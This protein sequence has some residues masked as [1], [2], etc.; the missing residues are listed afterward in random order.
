V[1]RT[2]ALPLVPWVA[3][4][5]CLAVVPAA[6]GAVPAPRAARFSHPSSI[7]AIGPW[8]VVADHATN[9]LTVLWA[10]DGAVAGRVDPA[11]LG[12][13]APTSVV[14]HL[15]GARREA[16]VAGSGGRVAVLALAARGRSLV[17][18]RLRMLDPTGC[19]RT[20][21][22]L[23]A[24][25]ARGHLVEAC[26]DGVLTEWAAASGALERVIPAA[27]THVTDAT[28]LAVLGADAVVVNAS[29]TGWGSAADG[30]TQLS[31]S[32]GARLRTVTDA[33]DAAY[34]F[35]GP[36]GITTDG[37]N[38]WEINAKGNT[39]DE[40]SGATLRFLAASGTNLSDPGAVIATP[41]FTWVSSSSW[42][43]QSSM[44]TQFVVAGH[45][46]QSPWM[47]CN[48]NDRYDFNDPSGFALRGSTLW[49]ANATNSVVDEMNASTGALV[50]TYR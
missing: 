31:L 4:A 14:A 8:I 27:T 43:G 16:F 30:V 28:G 23:L 44:V 13:A 1:S 42:P 40:L 50:A 7:A 41:T 29:T 32:T 47:M 19:A 38:Y 37:T 22:A 36:A 35:S 3:A 5:A 49:V 6:A 21:G 12:V 26:A 24:L 15:E 46:L 48:S 39:V 18:T 10:A 2:R 45:A 20:R 11:R 34:A 25:D 9:A 17:T 33:T